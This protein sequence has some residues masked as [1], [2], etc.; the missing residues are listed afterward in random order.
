MMEV[1][2]KMAESW[3]ASCTICSVGRFKKQLSDGLVKR[4]DS[5]WINEC[6]N[7]AMNDLGE[8]V[9]GRQERI[10][11]REQARAKIRHDYRDP[12]PRACNDNQVAANKRVGALRQRYLERY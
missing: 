5:P 11:T 6:A 7:G 1:F 3:D 9:R 8:V 2:H 10:T 4:S 12:Y